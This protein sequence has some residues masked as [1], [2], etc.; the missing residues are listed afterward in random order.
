[1]FDI[2]VIL[3]LCIFA[4]F[5]LFLL[6]KKGLL[7]TFERF[8]VCLM[9]T[10]L[11]FAIRWAVL[12][13][14]TLDYQNF[15]THWV[16]FFRNNGGFKALA[17]PVGNYNIPYLYFLAFFSYLDVRDLYLIKLLSIFFDVI[18]AWASMLMLSRF[19]SS[20]NRLT[21]CYFAVLF[22]PTVFLNGSLWAQCDAVY[23]ALA[24][25]SIYLALDNKPVLSMLCITL[26]FGFK[27]QA[28]FVMPIFAVLY[29]MGK[30]KL[31]HFLLFPISY[32]VLVMPAVIAGRPFWDCIS[33]YFNQTG[34]IG[35]GLNYN[36]PSVYAVFRNVQNTELASKLGIIAAF[37]FMLALLIV[38]FVFRNRLNDKSVLGAALLF[39]VGIPFL[40]PH[41]H[42]RYFFL[43][44]ILSLILAFSFPMFSFAFPLAQFAS[45]LGYHAYLKMR[46]L[47][48]MNYGASALIIVIALALI[49]FIS[50]LL[51]KDE[52]YFKIPL[53]IS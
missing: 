28:I 29:F 15:L 42:D 53:D 50:S 12:D 34:S 7:C 39:T 32:S 23:V 24:I 2:S 45:L 18:L 9:L 37:S 22:L 21:A 46:Y 5:S 31:K 11:A 20:K 3:T 51:E 16:S 6:Y 27:L 17:K 8:T 41:M 36:S 26:S 33:L 52:N 43:C 47:L 25:L 10:L 1:M 44:D 19:S 40:L 14:E 49:F 13:Y 30:F 35:S 38:C 4:V 48:T